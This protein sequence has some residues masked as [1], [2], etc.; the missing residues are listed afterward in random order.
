MAAFDR[1]IDMH[2]FI[3]CRVWVVEIHSSPLQHKSQSLR[4]I[5]LME[6]IR[7]RRIELFLNISLNH[8]TYLFY[9]QGKLYLTHTPNR[10]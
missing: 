9:R 4:I 5:L 3:F 10:N 2:I 8:Q 6:R 1:A 7:S